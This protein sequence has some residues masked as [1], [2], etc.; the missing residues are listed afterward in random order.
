LSHATAESRFWV[1][2]AAAPR[3]RIATWSAPSGYCRPIA[4]VTSSRIP[5][6]LTSTYRSIRTPRSGMVSATA[7]DPLARLE[8]EIALGRLLRRSCKIGLDENALASDHRAGTVL[9]G[10]HALPV[11]LA[12]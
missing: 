2:D 8:G 1:A 11:R 6:R 9:H 3:G 5:S 4:T 7:W 10:L 12:A